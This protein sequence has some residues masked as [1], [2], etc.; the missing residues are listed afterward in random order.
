[1]THFNRACGYFYQAGFIT[2]VE[3]IAILGY[4]VEGDRRI[5]YIYTH[6][7]SLN[8]KAQSLWFRKLAKSGLNAP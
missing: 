6:I 5:H 4:T 1:M 8:N 7:E 2:F 3:P